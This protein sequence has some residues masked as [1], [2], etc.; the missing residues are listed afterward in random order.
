MLAQ[1]NDLSGFTESPTEHEITVLNEPLQLA[2]VKGIIRAD[3]G[4]ESPLSGVL[5]EVRGPGTERIIRS[6]ITDRKGRFKIKGLKDG[7]YAFK[8][9][10][11]GFQSVV[12][13]IVLSRK[14]PHSNFMIKML[15][16]I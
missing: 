13:I 11:N 12:G 5:F 9:T 15:L 2:G 8:A 10:L 14:A 6:A 7:Q 16:G 3:D 1:D 4:Y